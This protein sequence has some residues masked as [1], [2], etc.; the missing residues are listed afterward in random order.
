MAKL[1]TVEH[2]EVLL[3]VRYLTQEETE[4]EYHW[5][6]VGDGVTEMFEYT[7]SEN[8]S[9]R[10]NDEH[11]VDLWGDILD[12]LDG[13]EGPVQIVI[14]AVY[15]FGLISQPEVAQYLDDNTGKGPQ[16][17]VV[18]AATEAEMPMSCLWLRSWE[19]TDMAS[20]E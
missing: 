12:E 16:F 14:D 7:L 11:Y 6:F 1:E 19:I 3:G 13:R 4:G 9:S 15:E 5:H 17:L 2:T 8:W 20:T 18:F 10:V